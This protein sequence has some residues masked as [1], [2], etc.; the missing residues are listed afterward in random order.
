MQIEKIAKILNLHS[1]PYY[2]EGGR[3]YADSMLAYSPIFSE[4][5]DLTD[6]TI[7]QLYSWLGY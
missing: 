3:I 6:Y 1:V 7:S 2:V 5:V 4:V